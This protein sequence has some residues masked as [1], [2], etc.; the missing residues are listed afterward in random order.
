MI[1]TMKPRAAQL[2][3]QQS[4]SRRAK[5]EE[6]AA[7]A[8]REDLFSQASGGRGVPGI[9]RNRDPNR[10][11][12][13]TDEWNELVEEKE[14]SGKS[15]RTFL[16]IMVVIAI[17]ILGFGKYDQEYNL[18][19]PQV[20]SG[21]GFAATTSSA[22]AREELEKYYSTLGV[23]QRM[24]PSDDATNEDADK[25]RR[26]DNYRVRQEIKR[27][28]QNHQQEQGQLVHC[29]RACH[30]SHNQ[31]QLAYDKLMSQVD[32]ELFGVLMD[33]P[34]T[35]SA[36]SA[37]PAELKAKYE[38]KRQQILETEEEEEDRNMALEELKDAYDIIQDPDA[39]KYYLLYGA[40]PP[41]HMRHASA[42]HGGWGQDM[43]LG[44]FKYRFII[45][46]LDFLHDKI[47]VW[48][49]TFVLLGLIFVA[50][51]R[52]PSALE[53]SYAILEEMDLLDEEQ[54]AEEGEASK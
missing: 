41:E 15:F 34:D 45:V 14:R 51:T 17:V 39:R 22:S 30:A 35:K 54:P 32:R 7:R 5:F 19:V 53:R 4:Q 52:L 6:S 1:V 47:G 50:L 40:K 8:Q 26:R 48:G 27:A 25:E 16:A 29:G 24:Q 42:R 11:I 43:A 33:A 10:G 9:I 31:V 44:T 21:R 3:Q 12:I 36:R 2:R 28:Y 38:A 37:S 13:T 49:E 18:E 46:W 23:H 20:E